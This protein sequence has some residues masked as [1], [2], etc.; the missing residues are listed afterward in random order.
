VLGC[1]SLLKRK[2]SGTLTLR[3]LFDFQRRLINIPAM[4]GGK[5]IGSGRPQGTSKQTIARNEIATVKNTAHLPKA[6][7]SKP[8]LEVL[9]SLLD[10]AL[11]LVQYFEPKAG[12]AQA[13]AG[14]HERFLVIARDTAK[15]LAKYQSPQLRA[16][17]TVTP[18][19]VEERF[20]SPRPPRLANVQPIDVMPV[21]GTDADDGD[22]AA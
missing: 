9:Q 19:V 15:E 5:R 16:I 8:A 13:D 4:R 18:P 6:G 1:R 17:I 2:G 12:N 14:R 22:D 11:E 3:A 10:Q 20:D 21:N 7:K